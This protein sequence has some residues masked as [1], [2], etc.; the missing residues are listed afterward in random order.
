[1]KKIIASIV[2]FLFVFV[3]V[4][5]AQPKIGDFAKDIVLKNPDGKTERLSNH[6]GKYV[7]VD[8]WASWCGP[9]RESNQELKHL[10]SKYKGKGFEIFGISLDQNIENWKTAIKAD[11]ITWKHVTEPGG[12]DAPVALAWGIEA[13]PSSFLLNKDGIIIEVNPSIELIEVYLE[14]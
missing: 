11:R 5:Q 8:F 13:L 9:C 6:K 12:W 14:N 1:M 10:Y 2:L 3:S 7:L 4:I